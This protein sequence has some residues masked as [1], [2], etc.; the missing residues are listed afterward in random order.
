M[1]RPS[2]AWERKELSRFTA[3]LP[4][5]GSNA[6]I[7]LAYSEFSTAKFPFL[8]RLERFLINLLQSHRHPPHGSLLCHVRPARSHPAM[9]VAGKRIGLQRSKINCLR[10]MGRRCFLRDGRANPLS[11][12]RLAYAPRHRPAGRS[13]CRSQR[14]PRVRPMASSLACNSLTRAA[15]A[16]RTP[17]HNGFR[18]F[19][20]SSDS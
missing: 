14:K 9:L 10:R 6:L 2:F 17:R 5:Q 1:S 11:G 13:T 8:Q 18:A 7:S 4:P 12:R 20:I 3:H 15:I 16:A 19:S